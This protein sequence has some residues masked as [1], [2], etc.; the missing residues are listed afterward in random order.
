MVPGGLGERW[1]AAG[2]EGG[3]D[4]MMAFSLAQPILLQRT[5]EGQTGCPTRSVAALII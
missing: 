1:L 2:R 3:Y 4:G 5:R